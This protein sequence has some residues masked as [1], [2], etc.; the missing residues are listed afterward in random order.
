MD[1]WTRWT[2]RKGVRMINNESPCPSSQLKNMKS[3][4]FSYIL[5]ISFKTLFV[6]SLILFF[7]AEDEQKHEN[8]LWKKK[9]CKVERYVSIYCCGN[10]SQSIAYSNTDTKKSVWQTQQ[11]TWEDLLRRSGPDNP[12][13]HHFHPPPPPPLAALSHS[14]RR[15]NWNHDG[16]VYKNCINKTNPSRLK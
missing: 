10:K 2:W 8:K 14:H 12:S 16:C 15:K 5:K 9:E 13:P 3:V 6:A 4:F 7:F 11:V 1:L